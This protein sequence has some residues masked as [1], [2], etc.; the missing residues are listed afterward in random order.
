LG[1]PMKELHDLAVSVQF[2]GDCRV[3]NQGLRVM[4][5]QIVRELLF[6]VVKHAGVDQ[7]WVTLQRVNDHL[8]ADDGDEGKGFD[9]DQALIQ[10]YPDFPTHP[11]AG[12]GSGG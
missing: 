4:I 5:F 9:P 1:V 2:E 7:A 3:K 11:A 6:N 12:G 8:V 10:R